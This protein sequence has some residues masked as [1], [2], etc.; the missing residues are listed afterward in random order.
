MKNIFIKVVKKYINLMEKNGNMYIN[1]INVAQ[2]YK[3]ILIVMCFL[4]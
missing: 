4:L 2:K 1:Y 3:F